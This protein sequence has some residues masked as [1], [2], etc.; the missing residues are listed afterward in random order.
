[1]P[2][3]REQEHPDRGDE[4]PELG[5]A[6]PPQDRDAERAEEL[7]GARGAERD[8]VHR[9]HEADRH[10]R[11]GDAE[12]Q[13]RGEAGPRERPRTGPDDREEDEPGADEAQAGG[14][15]RPDVVE[16]PDGRGDAQLHEEHRDERHAGA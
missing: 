1:M 4:R 16:Q 14:T 2:G 8:P 15:V 7:Q 6:A 3:L 10:H 11:D 13:R 9:G 5:P 12:P